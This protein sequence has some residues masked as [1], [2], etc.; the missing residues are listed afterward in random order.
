M[1]SLTRPV[2]LPSQPTA[3]RRELVRM[4]ADAGW[5][6][7]VDDVVLAVHEAMVNA[8]RHGGGL[9]RAA[10]S[11][12]R[13]GVTVEVCDRG[14]GFELPTAPDQPDWEAE[15]G[16]GLFLIRR[17]ADDVEVTRLGDDVCLL[18]R[19][20]RVTARKRRGRLC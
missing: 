2:E 7:D 16:R 12:D 1:S 20:G 19:F 18:L 9:V 14:R 17:L 15:R 5:D 3:A 4:L 8:S 6:G 10:A 13:G 11:V